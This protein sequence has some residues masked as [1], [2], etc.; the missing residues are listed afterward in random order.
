[1]VHRYQFQEVKPNPGLPKL[2]GIQLGE[3][4]LILLRNLR[5][6]VRL[7]IENSL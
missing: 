7:G 1:M 4:N 5:G 3:E 6:F 2:E